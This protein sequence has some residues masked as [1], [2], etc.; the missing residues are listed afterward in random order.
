MS[1]RAG[2]STCTNFAWL[3][4]ARD[5]GVFP[6]KLP[7]LTVSVTA[8][9]YNDENT[10]IA[11]DFDQM[12]RFKAVGTALHEAGVCRLWPALLTA[13]AVGLRRGEV[14][15]LRWRD[16]DLERR[17]LYIRQ[18]HT[19]ENGV[20]SFGKTKSKTSQRDI[21]MPLSL[22]SALEAHREAAE[23]AHHSRRH[24]CLCNAAR[25][26]PSPRQSAQDLTKPR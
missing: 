7:T 21:P 6:T 19:V 12:A 13:T 15:G 11:F 2:F 14:M 4:Q 25:H 20:H 9:T 17:K 3:R 1:I 23:I 5:A 22:H 24:G 16:V 26:V 10:G 8:K 18:N